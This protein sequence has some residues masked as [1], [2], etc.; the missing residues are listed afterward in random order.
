MSALPIASVQAA[1]L[2]DVGRV[3]QINEDA[4]VAADPVFMVADGMGGHE[5]GDT[6]S[7]IVAEEMRR[8]RGRPDVAVAEVKARISAARQR[9]AALEASQPDKQAGTTLSGVV[10]TLQN[11]QPYWLVV[12]LGDSRT[13]RF[14][15]Q[16]LE[17]LSVDHSEVQELVEG[18][19]LSPEQA[20]NHPRRNVVTKALGAGVSYE[21]DY[22]LVP[23]NS[24]D[25]ILVCSDGLSTE[26]PDSVIAGLLAQHPDPD[27]AAEALMDEALRAGAQDNVSVV[28]VN[29]VALPL[30]SDL[31]DT[32]VDHRAVSMDEDTIPRVN[33]LAGE[34]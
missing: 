14:A 27:G 18:G 11:G 5:A 22:W 19:R 21:P 32:T 20:R 3:R 24:D 10:V 12:N 17:Q 8:L 30:P 15:K 4:V 23:I 1:A 28:V 29:A 33:S 25:R 31:D 34:S 9:I 16:Q 7:A 13:Y 2:T 26:V 6:A